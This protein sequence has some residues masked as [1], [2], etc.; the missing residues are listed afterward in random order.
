M[1]DDSRLIEDYLPIVDI[2]AEASRREIRSQRPHLH[3]ASLVGAASARRLPRRRLWRARARVAVRAERRHRRQKKSLGRANAAK[4]VKTLCQYP[5]FAAQT[6]S[7][8]AQQHILEAHAERLI[9]GTG[10]TV[11]VEDIVAGRAPRPRVLDMFAGGGAIPLEACGWAAKPTR[12]TSIPL[13]TSSNFAR[14][15]I[16]RNMGSPTPMRAA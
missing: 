8:E 9:Q 3:A 7:R 14:S 1:S 4:F 13:L 10:K 16:R 5:R 2:S 11:T 6:V 12:S 15:S